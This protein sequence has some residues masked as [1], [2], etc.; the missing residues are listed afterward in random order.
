MS[1]MTLQGSRFDLLLTM[2]SS[3][4]LLLPCAVRGAQWWSTR[5]FT[6]Y[7]STCR[8]YPIITRLLVEDT[9]YQLPVRLSLTS[10]TFSL[11]FLESRGLPADKPRC[12]LFISPL[13][14]A[15][16]DCITNTSI[17]PRPCYLPL[18]QRT[19]SIL[20]WLMSQLTDVRNLEPVFNCRLIEWLT[21][22]IGSRL[23]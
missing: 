14:P 11:L 2:S 6:G 8:P 13:L 12:P 10:Y 3:T 18:F 17:H 22:Q 21:S 7:V 16:R 19:G 9:S 23:G 4:K 15:I 1:M 5:M 20:C